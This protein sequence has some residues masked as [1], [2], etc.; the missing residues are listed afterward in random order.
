MELFHPLHEHPVPLHQQRVVLVPLLLLRVLL[1][2]LE[3]LQALFAPL[4]LFLE[5]PLAL[6]LLLL[7]RV[8]PGPQVRPL[9][10]QVLPLLGEE[11]R[12]RLCLRLR[13]ESSFPVPLL[14][15]L[16]APMLPLLLGL[17][18]NGYGLALQSLP[19]PHMLLAPRLPLL[20]GLLELLLQPVLLLLDLRPEDVGVRVVYLLLGR[21][22]VRHAVATRRGAKLGSAPQHARVEVL[23]VAR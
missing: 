5:E 23:G 14:A 22:D 11:V 10:R 16:R 15:E 12:L 13:Q 6:L 9:V 3:Q 17:V 18:K 21:D 8:L 7:E 1:L 20:L 4:L 19:V 2:V